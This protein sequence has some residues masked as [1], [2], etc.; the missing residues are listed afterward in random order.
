MK[1]FG[2]AYKRNGQA[3]MH[4]RPRG[5]L[6]SR[7]TTVFFK[8]FL[9]DCIIIHEVLPCLHSPGPTHFLSVCQSK[10]SMHWHKRDKWPH[11]TPQ[12]VLHVIIQQWGNAESFSFCKICCFREP[13]QHTGGITNFWIISQETWVIDCQLERSV[14]AF[15]S[16]LSSLS[17][18]MIK[19]FHKGNTSPSSDGCSDSPNSYKDSLIGKI[20]LRL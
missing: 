13:M 7:L 9:S 14:Q 2:L 3:H 8:Y 15:D 6:L 11:P 4:K 16:N 17:P 1:V 19:D 18:K 10:P 12:M 20:F 5:I